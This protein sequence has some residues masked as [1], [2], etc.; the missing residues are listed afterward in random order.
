MSQ[1]ER[2]SLLI[3]F[4]LAVVAPILADLI[5]RI[6]VPVVVL[7]I[8]L[9]IVVGPHVLNWV[10]ATPVITVFS[11]FGLMFLFFLAGLEIDFKAIR[12]RPLTT[13][14]LGWFLSLGIALCFGLGLQWAGLFESGTLIAGALTTTAL[15]TLI[16]I[17]RDSPEAGTR[18]ANFVVA[19]GALGEFGPIVFISAFLSRGAM[20]ESAGG[21]FTGVLL[22]GALV[23]ITL[24]AAF[25]ASRVRPAYVVDL[26]HRKTH[27]SAQLPVR[28]AVALMAGLT[29]LTMRFGLDAVLGA[30]AAGIVVGL[31]CEGHT[32]EIVRHKLEGIA[33]G[34]FVPIFFIVTGV[35]FDLHALI[36]S[37]AVMARVLMFLLMFL[38]ARGAPALLC[39]RDL[40]RG[41][42]L[43][44][45][46]LSATALPLVVAISEVGVETKTLSTASATALVGAGMI[47]V[48]IFPLLALTLRSRNTLKVGGA[49][50]G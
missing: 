9:G 39:R 1:A 17:L 29:I 18:F 22:L 48:L 20:H 31:A 34:F 2:Y 35:K 43:P 25:L 23:A 37:G 50:A 46:L 28:V 27:T 19:A 4:A 30:M 41:D 8:V 40:P 42:L 13:A 24:V 11:R 12:G 47:S 44:L 7:E 21:G 10:Q 36:S 14:S 32:G 16:P 6:R 33:F 5:P 26:L 38:I 15:G 3:I 49:A 45:A